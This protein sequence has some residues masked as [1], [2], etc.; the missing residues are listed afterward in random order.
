MLKSNILTAALLCLCL[1]A[2]AQTEKKKTT[3]IEV[4]TWV[5]NMKEH[6]EFNGYA[7]AGFTY[8]NPNGKKQDYFDLKR[9]L[10]W[11]KAKVT[12]RWSFLFMH[13]FKSVVQEFYTD[14]RVS[15]DRSMTVRLGQFKNSLSMENPLSPTKQELIEVYSQSVTYLTGCG[16][17]PL[18]GVQYGR[19]LGLEIFGDVLNNKVHYELAVMNGAPIN[20]RDNNTQKDVIAHLEYK[21]VPTFRVVATGQLG[22]GHALATSVYCPNIK[23]D[24]D[25]TRNRYSAGV[26]WKSIAGGGDYWKHRAT[27]VHGEVIGGKDGDN[28]SIGAYVTGCVPVCEALDVVASVDYFNYNTDLNYKQTNLV[29]GVQHW[30]Y[31]KCRAQLQYTHCLPSK[32]MPNTDGNYSLL[33]AQL[34]VAF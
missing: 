6:F 14:Y 29:V 20:K 8:T 1:S 31:K 9:V 13:D 24:E 17:D 34:Q 33:Q 28:K 19:D 7:Q 12:D 25:Y 15:N 2:G 5:A 27:S 22:T 30:F 11:C 23:V 3:T 10:F 21:P 26:E 32:D 16:S 18:Y 4:P